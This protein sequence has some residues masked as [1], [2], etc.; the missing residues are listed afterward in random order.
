MRLAEAIVDDSLKLVCERI[1]LGVLLRHPGHRLGLALNLLELVLPRRLEL[2]TL[3]QLLVRRLACEH[4]VMQTVLAA[5]PETS[6][7]PV[8]APLLPQIRV[9]FGAI[10][11]LP[12]TVLD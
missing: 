10:V 11:G 1:V 4:V 6:L 9:W 3:N 2:R 7:A 5:G 8:L 12:L